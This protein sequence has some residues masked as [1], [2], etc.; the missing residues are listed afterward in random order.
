MNA[1]RT[2]RVASL[3]VLA[4]AL[5]GGCQ[6]A[7]TEKADADDV[8][9]VGNSV[10]F[11]AQSPQL[12]A[13]KVDSATI[14]DEPVH[15][16]T[17]RVVWDEDRTVRVYSP[18]AGR[19]ESIQ[20]KP[21]DAVQANRL[22]ATIASPDFGQTQ[23]ELQKAAADYAL[24]EKNLERAKELLEHGVAAAKDVQSASADYSRSQAEL[25]R[26]RARA[27]LYGGGGV[28][29]RFPLRTPLAGV[30]VERNVN[31]GQEV[32]PD[33]M[34][35]NVPPLFVVTDPTRVWVSLDAAETDLAILRPGQAITLRTPAYPEMAFAAQIESIADFI[36]PASRMIKVR[37]SVANA[38]RKLKGE[39]FVTA[40]VRDDRQLALMV[41]AAAVILV[42][43]KHYA[44]SALGDGRFTRVEVNVGR[45][46][47]G[48]VRVTDGIAPGQHVV[49][50][51]VLLLQQLLQSAAAEPRA[52][53]AS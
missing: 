19:V 52:A 9:V 21:G 1:R 4:A 16:L 43:S 31:P 42:G 11:P 44:F 23:S 25:A 18:F 53:P 36:D 8:I 22:L 12:A 26:V 40:E 3:A 14:R 29:Q 46:S 49:S 2:A 35:S 50:S 13:F 27:A 6:R 51:S 34:T 10:R 37:A 28:D 32:R 33:Q 5:I 30:V 38:E 41:P 48:W 15:R 24:A 17:G 39:M 7:P 47:N 20:A 45:E